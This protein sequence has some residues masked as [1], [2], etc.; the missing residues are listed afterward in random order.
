MG[1][2]QAFESSNILNDFNANK[3]IPKWFGS[4]FAGLI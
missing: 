1:N 2:E 3:N 4:W